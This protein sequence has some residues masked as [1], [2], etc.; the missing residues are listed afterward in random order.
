WAKIPGR[1]V[2]NARVTWENEDG[3]KLG[4]EVQNLTDKYYFQSVSDVTT[5][6]GLVTGVPAMPRTYS[7][8][9]ERRF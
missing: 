1:L 6:L 3:W 2:S 9:V 7:A 8:F 4:M 5:S